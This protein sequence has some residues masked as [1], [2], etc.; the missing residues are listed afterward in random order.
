[1]G[2]DKRKL[3]VRKGL[4]GCIDRL[5][6]PGAGDLE[7]ALP[8]L[9]ALF[10]SIMLLRFAGLRHFH[11]VFVQYVVAFLIT[12]DT[13]GGAITLAMPAA[14]KWYHRPERKPVSY[15]LFNCAHI[16]PFIIA[17]VFVPEMQ[18][19]YPVTIYAYLVL[20]TLFL[21]KTPPALKGGLAVLF[22]VFGCFINIYMVL[23]PLGFVWFVPVFYLKL[24]YGNLVSGK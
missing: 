23:P 9:V 13:V 16:H 3:E 14:K 7:I 12:F 4:K 18:W 22:I 5:F 21:L 2:T 20:T 8:I 17:W 19:I 1:M 6:G 11:W 15:F 10:V 24:L